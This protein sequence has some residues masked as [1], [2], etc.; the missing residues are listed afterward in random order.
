M[1]FR[2]PRTTVSPHEAVIFYP[3]YGYRIDAENW[4]IVVQ[5]CVYHQRI[6]WL[7]RK[8][9]LSVIR[10]AMR[11]G[12]DSEI[13]FRQ[14]M[15]QFLVHFSPGRQVSIQLG[16]QIATFGPT[17]HAG[18]FR[19]ELTIPAC[20]LAELMSESATGAPRWV[21]Y[22]ATL[23][24][25]DD[26]QFLGNAQLLESSGVSIISDVD[27]TLKHSNVPNRG[28]LFQN[29]FVREFV[30]IPGMPELYRECAI[31]GAAFHYVS[32]SPW[33]L[34]EPLAEFWQSQG[35]PEGSFHLKRF[36]LRESASKL[37]MSLQRPHKT[38]AIEPI[39]NSF[40]DRK[41]ILIGD[42]GEQDPEI[43]AHFL[44][45]RPMQVLHVFIRAVRGIDVD[46]PRLQQ[47]FT[48]VPLL[49]WSAYESAEEIHQ[50]L[51]RLV[52]SSVAPRV[53]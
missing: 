10:R 5:G 26:R 48:D 14:R 40:P 34:Y 41:F 16:D 18:L 51:L 19:G 13:F 27:D 39:L 53:A 21:Q 46:L 9:V 15:R 43:Y 38:A 33:Q 7:R 1:P 42:A 23:P 29:T 28:D 32:G 22:Q 11:V 36:R 6:T 37:R 31:R 24:V 17:E 3:S 45:E 2:R 12:R 50:P 44:R 25:G 35:Y 20:Q 8:P 47:T 52:E 4:A 49:S 30:S